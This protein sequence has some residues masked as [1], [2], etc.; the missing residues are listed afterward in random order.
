MSGAFTVTVVIKDRCKKQR[1]RG[2]GVAEDSIEMAYE[3]EASNYCTTL[4]MH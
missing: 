2:M 1:G 3:T 4:A